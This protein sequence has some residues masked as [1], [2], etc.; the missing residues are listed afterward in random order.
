MKKTMKTLVTLG[1]T[2]CLSASFLMTAFAGQWKQDSEYGNLWWYQHDDGTY[3]TD[4]WEVIDGKHYHFDGSGWLDTNTITSDGYTVD[5]N[6]VW[7]E[8]IPQKTQEEIEQ[9]LLD[10]KQ[11]LLDSMINLYKDLDDSETTEKE[12]IESY[13]R[14]LYPDQADQIINDLRG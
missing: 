6:G 3:P 8:S 13:I 5:E 1:A 2:L 9:D 14:L 10:S 7:I 4:C 12:E 11:E